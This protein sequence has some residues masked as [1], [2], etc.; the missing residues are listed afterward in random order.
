[1]TTL[2]RRSIIVAVAAAVAVATA[3]ALL[4]E[5]GSWY[6][7][8]HVPAWKPP[9]W[10]FGPIWTTIFSLT[11]WAGLRGWRDAPDHRYRASL[12]AL[13]AVNAASN[14]AWSVLF[15]RL[16]RPDWAFAEVWVLWVSIVA[17]LVHLARTSP[18]SGILMLPYLAWVSTAACLNYSIILLNGPFPGR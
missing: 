7:G 15:F 11:T 18:L 3:G 2:T 1:V 10:A 12:V 13:M 17:L 6:Q 8:L 5:L 9:D 14:I 4:T 16:Y